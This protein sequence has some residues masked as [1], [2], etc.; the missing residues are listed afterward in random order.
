MSYEADGIALSVFVY[1][2]RKSCRSLA[3]F[4]LAKGAKS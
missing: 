1:G 2:E 4:P 3:R